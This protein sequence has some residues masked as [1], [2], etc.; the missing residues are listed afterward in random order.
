MAAK[1]LSRN[2]DETNRIDNLIFHLRDLDSSQQTIDSTTRWLV[3]NFCLFG[4]TYAILHSGK[5]HGVEWVSWSPETLFTQKVHE[6]DFNEVALKFQRTVSPTILSQNEIRQINEDT[7]AWAERN[8]IV[9]AMILPIQ[10]EKDI[11]GLF[12]MYRADDQPQF[13]EDDL[14]LAAQVAGLLSNLLKWQ[15]RQEESERRVGELDQMLRASLSMTESLKLEDVLNAI[16]INA[17]KLLPLVNDAHIFLYEDNRIRFGAALFQNGSTGKAWAE[18]RPNGLTYQVA[19]G[20]KVILVEDMRT[21]PLFADT[22]HNWLGSIIGI[23]LLINNSV[24]GVMTLA[25]LTPSGFRANEIELLQRLAIQAGNVIQNVRSHALISQQAFT[26]AL[27]N[28]PNRRSF[29]WEAQKVIAHSERYERFFSLAMLDL[30]GFKRI[31]DTYGHAIG[32]DSLRRLASCMRNAIRKTDFLARFGGD[33]FII[34][35]PETPGDLAR[36]VLEKLL[37]RVAECPIPVRPECVE[38][39]SISYG[40]ACYPQDGADLMT[41]IKLADH[42]LY[43]FKSAANPVDS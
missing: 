1:D 37:Q 35:F 32:D 38:T 3:T 42:H 39:L 13:G 2:N 33:E 26:D 8:C 28:L 7:T 24:L 17:L 41:L 27:T 20:G 14:E 15:M 4:C 5:G 23:P 11:N 10:F 34:L 16:L 30:D 18:P 22:P 12:L 25:K 43:G 19:R 21:H 29:E 40:L 31:N 6:V 36:E 9:S